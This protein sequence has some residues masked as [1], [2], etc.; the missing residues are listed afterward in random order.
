MILIC[1]RLEV[2]IK[3]Q[4]RWRLRWS[5]W[6]SW[7][8]NSTKPGCLTINNKDQRSNEMSRIRSVKSVSEKCRHRKISDRKKLT[9]KLFRMGLESVA[10]VAQRFLWPF[11][12]R[13]WGLLGCK[14]P[15]SIPVR[16]SVLC[17]QINNFNKMR[18][19]A[20]KNFFHF[21][22]HLMCTKKTI[23]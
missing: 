9:Y 22:P 5:S 20:N 7:F 6:S 21:T 23:T 1:L 13:R 3:K 14:S 10:S 18:K 17:Q 8:I 15:G 11:P 19:K 16:S 12:A 2:S 4:T